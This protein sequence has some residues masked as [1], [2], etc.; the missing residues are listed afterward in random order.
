[1]TDPENK[2]PE[3]ETE[4]E[5]ESPTPVEGKVAFP[6]L[7]VIIVAVLLAL[8]VILAIIIRLL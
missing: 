1:M 8:I 2:T 6:R 7:G 5:N 4:P 3:N